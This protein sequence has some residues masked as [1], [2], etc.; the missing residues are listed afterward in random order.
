MARLW[1]DTAQWQV[2][3]TEH[4]P[5]VLSL[6]LDASKAR[7]RLGWEPRLDLGHA[8]EW[9]VEWY[10]RVHGG[11]AAADVSEEQIGRYVRLMQEPS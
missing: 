2:D 6:H 7:A 10:R 1:S 8:L 11:E 9:T 3:E 4:P 5:E